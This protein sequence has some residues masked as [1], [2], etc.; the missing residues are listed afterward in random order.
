MEIATALPI[1]IATSTLMTEVSRYIQWALYYFV[2]IKAD[3]AV[4]EKADSA[5]PNLK[6][7]RLQVWL[8][9]NLS[10]IPTQESIRI[11]A[12]IV[13]LVFYLY[14]IQNQN[15][16]NWTDNSKSW[17]QVQR[18][19]AFRYSFSEN[20]FDESLHIPFVVGGYISGQG[21]FAVGHLT[22][23]PQAKPIWHPFGPIPI[24]H[25]SC[26]VTQALVDAD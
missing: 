26:P 23:S 1:A 14:L 17:L 18:A 12:H 19:R 13:K 22:G 24:G 8:V 3:S 15:T 25:R 6:R 21:R 10:D 20:I 11:S 5:V 7:N 9:W 4:P 16:M 2:P